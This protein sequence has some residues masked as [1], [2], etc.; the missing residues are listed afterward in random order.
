MKR[1]R[2]CCCDC[3]DKPLLIVAESPVET[4]EWDLSDIL[5]VHRLKKYKKKCWRIEQTDKTP[6]FFNRVCTLA[7]GE[8]SKDGK[9]LDLPD[10]VT[11]KTPIDEEYSPAR[12]VVRCSRDCG[13]TGGCEKCGDPGVNGIVFKTNEG[14]EGDYWDLSDLI[15]MQIPKDANGNS[16][17]IYVRIFSAAVA[18]LSSLP[19]HT[20]TLIGYEKDANEIIT[21]ITGGNLIYGDFSGIGELLENK[22]KT[23]GLYAELYYSCN[24]GLC[25]P[26]PMLDENDSYVLDFGCADELVAR[27]FG[28]NGVAKPGSIWR[29][30]AAS[31]TKNNYDQWIRVETVTS[32]YGI[33]GAAGNLI[34]LPSNVSSHDLA[35]CLEI[36][37]ANHCGFIDKSI[38]RFEL[39]LFHEVRDESAVFLGR[40]TIN[41]N[42]GQYTYNF[43]INYDA[44][45]A[46]EAVIQNAVCHDCSFMYIEAATGYTELSRNALTGHCTF[47]NPLISMK[48]L[49]KG[50][51][52]GTYKKEFSCRD[53]NPKFC[54]A[55][56]TEL[57]DLETLPIRYISYYVA[58]IE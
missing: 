36:T 22:T 54:P 55:N 51:I 30:Q 38:S 28:V 5:P 44:S 14:V 58:L 7:V 42:Y 50:T 39:G 2:K 45:T 37:S 15:G 43:E 34:G 29:L 49:N 16:Y 25:I 21:K 17:Q 20:S 18:P 52:V 33:V 23:N 35:A 26:S 41:W 31:V 56:I 13:K 8:I 48:I 46:Y 19:W 27:Y 32:Q 6:G 40:E 1:I 24:N 9:L 47:D 4:T 11:L 3:I 12:L 53:S 57:C 10:S